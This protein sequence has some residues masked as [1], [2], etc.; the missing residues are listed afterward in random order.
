MVKV[1]ICG[2]TTE[3]SVSQ[4]VKC[5]ASYVGF[6]FYNKSPRNVDINTVKQFSKLIPNT[7]NK[8]GLFVNP[9]MEELKNHLTEISL[10]Y[11]QLH[12][13]ETP[14]DI[15]QIKEFFDIPIIKAIGISEVSD[16]EEIEKYEEM[17]DQLLI[18]AKPSPKMVLPGGN[19]AVFDWGLISNKRF[20]RPWFLAGGL[21]SFNVCEAIRVSGAKQVDVS[22]GVEKSLGLKENSRIAD[23]INAVKM[24]V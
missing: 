7:V 24:R 3:S 8:V 10:D 6:V 5:G 11:V 14:E 19:G 12:G 23:F 2:L 4:S 15:L 16:L 20:N 13:E 21:S 9:T 18:D 1:K 17:C 22:S